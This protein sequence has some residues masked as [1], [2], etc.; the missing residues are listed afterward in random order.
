MSV[1]LPRGLTF[2]TTASR[3]WSAACPLQINVNWPDHVVMFALALVASRR[4]TAGRR[5]R[6]SGRQRRAQNAADAAS[7]AA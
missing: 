1:I 6:Q 3:F 2:S 7:L 5:S 4:P